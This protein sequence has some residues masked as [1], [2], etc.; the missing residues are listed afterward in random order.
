ETVDR[1][2][3]Q[4]LKQCPQNFVT[5]LSGRLTETA[6]EEEIR[7]KMI[8]YERSLEGGME[9]LK[10]NATVLFYPN[11]KKYVF[12][13]YKAL[14]ILDSDRG[15]RGQVLCQK[16]QE[17]K[18]DSQIYK[19]LNRLSLL[20]TKGPSG[21][22][23]RRC[24]KFEAYTR[25]R[26]SDGNWSIYRKTK[27]EETANGLGFLRFLIS[28]ERDDET[29]G[30]ADLGYS[31]GDEIGVLYKYEIPLEYW[32][33]FLRRTISC[34][35]EDAM[36]DLIMP[37][38]YKDRL[39]RFECELFKGSKDGK[40]ERKEILDPPVA[41]DDVVYSETWLGKQKIIEWNKTYCLLDDA[42]VCFSYKL[43][44]ED[45]RRTKF[46]ELYPFK[47]YWD[48]NKIFDKP[49]EKQTNGTGISAA[50]NK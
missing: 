21:Q 18:K 4:E 32:G 1:L 15:Y 29:N 11:D 27:C 6:Q 38:E 34:F 48:A 20:D 24:I 50:S 41:P 49:G 28:F 7:N 33:N 25:K 3:D 39:N 47:L 44:V 16:A 40:Q 9:V 43:P 8:L 5:W 26:Q 45:M 2:D 13:I 31:T 30:V 35:Y 17:V 14:K 36:L 42:V 12:F 37:I 10:N 23:N 22:K 19:N 46:R